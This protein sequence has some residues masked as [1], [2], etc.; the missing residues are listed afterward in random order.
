MGVE[1]DVLEAE[2]LERGGDAVEDVEV[3]SARQVGAGDLDAGEVAV[4]PDADLGEAES[5]EVVFGAFDLGKGLG[6]DG[7]AVLDARGKAG[8]GGFVGEYEARLAGQGADLGF[9]KLGGDERSLG[10]VKRGGLLA[11]A[12]LAAVVKVHAVGDVGEASGAPESLHL[13]EELVFAVEAASGIVAGV[14]GVRELVGLQDFERDVLLL[15]KGQGGGEL[16]ARQGG[17]IG[18]DGEH[19]RAK[20]LVGGKGEKGG[21]CAARVGDQDRAEVE[22]GLMQQDGFLL[23]IH[24][25]DCRMRVGRLRV[26]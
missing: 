13:G 1:R 2:H 23:E 14:V 11:G 3:K 5:M 24:E 9:G 7:T 16:F 17:G 25:A 19:A 4:V 26:S 12:E 10:V 6:G 8:A 20:R 22:E 15:G 18:D 21:V